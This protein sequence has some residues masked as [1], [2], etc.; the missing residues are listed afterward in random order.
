MTITHVSEL[1]D[2]EDD[3]FNRAVAVLDGAIII[4]F[5][6]FSAMCIKDGWGAPRPVPDYAHDLNAAWTL[7]LP[8]SVKRGVYGGYMDNEDAVAHVVAYHFSATET[9]ATPA[10]A[11]STAWAAWKLAQMAQEAG[12]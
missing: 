10:R 8:R 9:H 2:M 3:A 1:Y 11:L 7:A 4:K 12:A 5:S 6:T